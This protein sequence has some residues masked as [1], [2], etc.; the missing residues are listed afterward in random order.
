MTRRERL[1]HPLPHVLEHL[2]HA[3]QAL[4]RQLTL[5]PEVTW[6]LRVCTVAL[7]LPPLRALRMTRLR[8]RC[9][10]LPQLVLQDPQRDQPDSLQFLLQDFLERQRRRVRVE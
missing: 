6:H 4:T 2:L 5:Q 1:C 3:P 7:H 8:R 9:C 10:P